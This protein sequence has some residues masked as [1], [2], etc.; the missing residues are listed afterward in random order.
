M[1]ETLLQPLTDDEFNL[2]KSISCALSIHKSMDIAF[3]YQLISLAI[4]KPHH[5][6]HLGAFKRAITSPF[7][8]VWGT[9]AILPPTVEQNL[10]IPAQWKNAFSDCVGLTARLKLYLNHKSLGPWLLRIVIRSAF[11][12]AVLRAVVRFE[13]LTGFGVL[14]SRV[15]TGRPVLVGTMTEI[16]RQA[17]RNLVMAS[18]FKVSV[19][20]RMQICLDCN[21]TASLDTKS[22]KA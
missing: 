15:S 19:Q 7:R 16:K 4:V 17:K 20:L 5:K 9:H 18:H 8:L 13:V 11:V 14:R 2:I 6:R 21:A 22:R 12:A 1:L 3:S 10:R